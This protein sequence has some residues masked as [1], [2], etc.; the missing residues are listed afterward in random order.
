MRFGA[1]TLIG[2]AALIAA[3]DLAS[4][5]NGCGRGW[6]WNGRV[7]APYAPYSGYGRYEYRT[8]R[9]PG[10]AYTWQQ[11]G[12]GMVPTGRGDCRPWYPT[13]GSECPPGLTLQGGRCKP[14]RGY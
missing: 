11:C 14:Y 7:C 10:G 8:P 12:R 4:A 13:R 3:P 9:H 6:Y 1:F 5:R 2:L